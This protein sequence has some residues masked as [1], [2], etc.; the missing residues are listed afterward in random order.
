MTAKVIINR[1]RK[2][3]CLHSIRALNEAIERASIA[4]LAP[5]IGLRGILEQIIDQAHPNLIKK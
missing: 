2:Q 4:N 5:L 3:D 1:P